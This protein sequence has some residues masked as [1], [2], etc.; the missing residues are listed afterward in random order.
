MILGEKCFKRLMVKRWQLSKNTLMGLPPCATAGVS[1][2]CRE[3]ARAARAQL[4]RRQWLGT[5]KQ[6]ALKSLATVRLQK[7]MVRLGFYALGDHMQPH[8]VCQ[9][10]DGVR[11]GC[12]VGVV[13]DALHKALVDLDLVQ[14][15]ALE[16]AQRRIAGAKVVQRKAHTVRL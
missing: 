9:H 15:Q 8:R 16:V 4:K 2:G 5:P 3:C 1:G 14:R 12:V 11:N 10:D 7:R 6:V 13:Q